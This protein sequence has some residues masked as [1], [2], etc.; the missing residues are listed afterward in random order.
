MSVNQTL[1]IAGLVVG[2]FF[3]ASWILIWVAK[4]ESNHIM[5]QVL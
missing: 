3:A 4:I 5:A 2:A 1:T